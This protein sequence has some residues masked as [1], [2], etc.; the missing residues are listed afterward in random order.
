MNNATL[1]AHNLAVQLNTAFKGTMVELENRTEI[2]TKRLNK[3]VVIPNSTNSANL[4]LY[5][6]EAGRIAKFPA[7]PREHQA[8]IDKITKHSTTPQASI[9]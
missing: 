2:T 7:N 9:H 6:P 3:I 8:V 1:A 4:E 5:T